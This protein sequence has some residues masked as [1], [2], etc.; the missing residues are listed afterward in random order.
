MNVLTRLALICALF[1]LALAQASADDQHPRVRIT[2]NMG[3]IVLELDREKA[4]K[5]VDNFLSYVREGF[6]DGTIFH[7]VIDGFMIQGGGFTQDFQKK[8]TRTPVE[9]EA[10]NGLKNNKGTIAMA[11]TNAPHSATAQFFINVADNDFLNHRSPTPRGWGYAVFGKVVQG[12]DVV[13]KIRKTPT[14]SGGPFRKDVP[15]TPVII[16]KMTLE[17]GSP[18]TPTMQ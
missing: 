14:G 6:Y 13:D 4:P 5:T 15:R 8:P 16:E 3:D 7:R 9:N 12:M 11:R 10:N 17:S 2:T 18:S 1:V